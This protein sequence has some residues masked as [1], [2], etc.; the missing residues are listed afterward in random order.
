MPE[1]LI[2]FAVIIFFSIIDAISRRRKARQK[3]QSG[4]S[5]ELPPPEEWMPD[6]LPSYDADPSY[7]DTAGRTEKQAAT[8]QTML[9][10]AL[11]E[12]LAGLAGRLEQGRGQARTL[13]LPNQ[14]PELPEP[15]PEPEWVHLAPDRSRGPTQSR[16]LVP[17]G[18]RSVARTAP[19]L[20]HRAHE[21]YGTDPSE[22]AP[23]EQDGLDPLAE[24][25]GANAA[26]IRTQLL[27]HT[28]AGLRQAVIL[29]EVLGKP[30]SLRD[31]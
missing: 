23:S 25:L 13:D 19:H 5:P 30:V 1:E 15:E 31:E 14:S 20:V 7:D 12:E 29:Q 10:S 6:D 11:F 2:F 16:S 24:T 18:R 21:G 4:E 22:R 26:A 8:S 17:G 3:A 28:A 9:P 27:S